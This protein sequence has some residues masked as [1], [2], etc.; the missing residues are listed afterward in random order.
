MK[1][2]INKQINIIAKGIVCLLF[3]LLLMPINLTQ[4]G[5]LA[6]RLDGKILLQV[7]SRGEAWYVNPENEKRYYLGRPVD[8]FQAM[9]ELGLGV[10]NKDFDSWNG[11][12]PS[13]LSGRI[14]LKAEDNGKAYYV[15]TVDLK[16]HYLGRPDDA[17]HVMR[18]LG[19]GIKNEY[20][21]EIIPASI[22][23]R[24]II[25]EQEIADK[26]VAEDKKDSNATDLEWQIHDLIN[27]KRIASGIPTMKWSNTIARIARAHSED[28]VAKDY[29]EHKD[30]EGCDENCRLDKNNY[31]NEHVNQ[32]LGSEYSYKLIYPNGVIAQYAT[33]DEIAVSNVDKWKKFDYMLNPYLVYEGIGTAENKDKLIYITSMMVIP[34]T[35]VE[36]EQELKEF[37]ATIIDQE[38][39]TLIKIKKVYDWITMNID[40]DIAGYLTNPQSPENYISWQVFKN[41][42]GICQGY[43]NLFALMLHYAGISAEVISGTA[44]NGEGH[45]RHAW[46]KIVAEGEYLYFDTTWS[47]GYVQDNEF[48]RQTSGIY[49]LL[50]KKCIIVNHAEEGE[51]KMT[52]E[53]Q[54]KYVEENIALF[55]ARCPLLRDVIL[56]K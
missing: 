55:D 28:M 30:P 27:K 34:L 41:K 54:K 35:T 47:A 32:Y 50:P 11:K 21:E 15:N 51:N 2:F 26:D 7:E 17:F 29:L 20:L 19:L 53:E 46:S 48:T 56:N 23:Q 37:I 16:M 42:K 8:A 38:D 4:A 10:S 40:Y 18:L 52:S 39:D 45:D 6:S 9:R 31:R 12:A 24:N 49:Y 25:I 5:D 43:S 22:Q 36:Q 3:F 44:D 14:L 13:R 33:I 1:K